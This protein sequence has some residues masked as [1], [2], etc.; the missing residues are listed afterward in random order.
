MRTTIH[1]HTHTLVSLLLVAP[2]SDR[3]ARIAPGRH[4]CATGSLS[5][6]LLYFALTKTIII[7]EMR[8]KIMN[9]CS[10]CRRRR[11][12]IP[13]APS[14]RPRTRRNSNKGSSVGQQL[15]GV[16]PTAQSKRIH[17]REVLLFSAWIRS[18]SQSDSI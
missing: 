8:R 14:S 4:N 17:D 9:A 12:C 13:P 11:F 5:L 16:S 10:N 15:C 3:R 7:V 6:S 18:V 2:S 1:T